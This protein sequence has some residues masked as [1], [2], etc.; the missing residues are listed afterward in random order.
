M[1]TSAY[2]R[3]INRKPRKPLTLKAQALRA[4]KMSKKSFIKTPRL[5][6]ERLQPH[7]K[8]YRGPVQLQDED[9]VIRILKGETMSL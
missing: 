1:K 7:E 5:P 6:Q 2:Q 4:L 9:Q 3:R 8:L